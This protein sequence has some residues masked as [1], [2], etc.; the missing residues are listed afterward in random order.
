MKNQFG[1]IYTV[2][3]VISTM[4]ISRASFE[5]IYC[6]TVEFDTAT[7]KPIFVTSDAAS[8]LRLT[9]YREEWDSTDSVKARIS[10]NYRTMSDNG[11]TY[12]LINSVSGG[13]T[14]SDLQVTALSHYIC[15]DCCGF[16]T[17]GLVNFD[18]QKT[19]TPVSDSFTVNCSEF[20]D[21]VKVFDSAY[22]IGAYY[23]LQLVRKSSP[24]TFTLTN[25][26]DA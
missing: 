26:L 10:I 6:S 19:Y 4:Q 16:K 9:A 24:W 14:I 18:Q 22:P 15:V 13:Y 25:Y 11:E 23:E 2:D 20:T 8:M 12:Y 7:A 21:Y 3:A 5:T 17:N 1:E